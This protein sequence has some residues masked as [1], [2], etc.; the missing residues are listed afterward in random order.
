M[1]D[2]PL[3]RSDVQATVE[4]I[5][6]VQRGDGSIPWYQGGQVDPWN[7]VESAM[8]LDVGGR[9]AEASRAYDWLGA[10]QRPDG[11]WHAA[12]RDGEVIDA[13]L[14]TN[15]C[16][17][18]AT[19]LWLHL[20]C[21]RPTSEVRTRFACLERALGFVLSHQGEDGAV[22]W[23]CDPAGRPWR[24]GLVTGSSCIH[25]SLAC[26]TRLGDALG[27]PHPQ[28]EAARNRLRGAL[29]GAPHSFQDKRRWAMDWYYP[30]LCGVVCEGDARARIAS[31]WEQFVV[32][33]R[34]VRCVSDRPWIT[35]AETCELAL[36]LVRCGDRAGAAQLL[37]WAQH[38]RGD[39]AA[40]WTGA[41]FTDGRI[42]PPDEQPTWTSAA[43][44]LADNAIS[45]GVVAEVLDA[46][47]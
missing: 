25:L 11:A 7:H 14:D 5:A 24:R 23:A 22:W 12:Y 3:S 26:A 43:V 46:T 6:R 33:E 36:A 4:A 31:R 47:R 8:A 45:G 16:A 35:A 40:Y 28:W 20:L 42:F 2:A 9:H 13:T 34:G 29:R 44:V 21:G 30:V 27:L 18:V 15:L 10:T 19:G 41:N 39:D 1:I 38:L 17:Y 32:P 37:D